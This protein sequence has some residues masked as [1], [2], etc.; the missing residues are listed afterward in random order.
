MPELIVALD[1]AV[2][3]IKE[4]NELEKSKTGKDCSDLIA[5]PYS[6]KIDI[7]HP[8]DIVY[9]EADGRYTI[10]HLTNGNHKIASRNLGEYEKLLNTKHFFRIHHSYIVNLNMVTNINKSSGN[11][12]ELLNNKALPIAKRRQEQLHR[13]LKIK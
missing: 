10:F 5:I 3:S 7:I 2:K 9:I 13:F 4:K 6:N 8:E 11:Y 1:K 12:C